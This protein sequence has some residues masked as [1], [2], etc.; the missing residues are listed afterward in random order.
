LQNTAILSSGILIFVC[1]IFQ[2]VLVF[3]VI[4]GY[5]RHFNQIS[6]FLVMKTRTADEAQQLIAT[7]VESPLKECSKAPFQGDSRRFHR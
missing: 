7:P 6:T 5:Y 1:G 4:Y 2:L 3:T